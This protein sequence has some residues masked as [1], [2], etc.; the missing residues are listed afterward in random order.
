MADR[1][2][3]KIMRKIDAMNGSKDTDNQ[4]ANA[5]LPAMTTAIQIKG[6]KKKSR[7]VKMNIGKK[8]SKY[9]RKN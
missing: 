7:K 2:S 8:S 5:A 3:D 6:G 4:D 9:T 1:I